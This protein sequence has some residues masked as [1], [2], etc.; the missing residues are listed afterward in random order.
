MRYYDTPTI[1][2]TAEQQIEQIKDYLY[3][4]SQ[5]LNHN[6]ENTTVE[7]FWQKT[8]DAFNSSGPSGNTASELDYDEE[9]LRRGQYV[10]LK[11]LIIQAATEI[12]KY[13]DRVIKEYNAAYLAKSEFGEYFEKAQVIIDESAYGINE[14]YKYATQIKTT[15]DGTKEKV[16]SYITELEGYIKRGIL[17]EGDSPVFGMEI[18]YNENSFTY[19]GVEYPNNKPSKI[20]I[21]P[22]KISF[23]NGSDENGNAYEAA[24]INEN[25][26]HFPKAHIKG[27][28]IKID[29]NFYVDAMG[30]M[31]ATSATLTGT[32][33]ANAGYIGGFEITGDSDANRSFWPCSIASIYTPSDGTDTDDYQY[34]VFFRGNNKEDG[35]E[36]GA[37]TKE[38]VVFGIKK[39]KKTVTT[40]KNDTAPYVY[41]VNMKGQVRT[42]YLH[43]AGGIDAVGQIKGKNLVSETSVSSAYHSVTENK[44][45][46]GSET[47]SNTIELLTSGEIQLGKFASKASNIYILAKDTVRIGQH[48]VN[49]L[50]DVDEHYPSTQNVIVQANKLITIGT[51]ENYY[52]DEVRIYAGKTG[53]MGNFAPFTNNAYDCGSANFKW[54]Y[55]YSQYLSAEEDWIV[56][57]TRGTEKYAKDI[58]IRT[59]GKLILGQDSYPA[60]EAYL[61]ATDGIRIGQYNTNCITKVLKL[62]ASTISIGASGNT[63]NIGAS[64]AIVNI[65]GTVKI[66]GVTQ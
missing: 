36:Y 58:Y 45:S 39:R 25:A 41:S 17:E 66:N 44:I 62:L 47:Y 3:K 65:S 48:T 50:T 18:G 6:L 40:W 13:E 20:R 53:I 43:S 23:I 60:A 11:D 33:V 24:Y 52:P 8:F 16:D 57:G 61:V 14:L 5:D 21:T 59:D 22:D 46:F 7:K 1:S 12:I 30:N 27:G 15:S 42:S 4:Q 49:S 2:G 9:M 19:N 51:N 26:I 35:S 32:V 37:E 63:I 55:F 31:K 28:T 38:H 64:N 29:P 56:I 54:R 34:A 10:S